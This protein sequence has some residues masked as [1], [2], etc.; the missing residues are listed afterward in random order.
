MGN[1]NI[2]IRV[3]II[4]T[5]LVKQGSITVFQELIRHLAKK[6]F[7]QVDLYYFDSRVD[8]TVDCPIQRITFKGELPTYNYDVVHS[9]GL[10]PDIYVFLN[11]KKFLKKTKFLTTI[12]SFIR[13]DLN[14]EYNSIVSSVASFFWYKILKVQDVVVVL[15]ESAKEYYKNLLSS[16]LVV[17]NNGRTVIQDYNTPHEDVEKLMVLVHKYKIIGTHA[18]I[19]HIKSL[20]T[21]IKALPKLPEY[22]FVVIGKGRDLDQLVSLAKKIGVSERCLFLG[23]R[24][25]ILPYFQYY[26]IYT[27]PSLSEGLPMALIEAVANKIPCLCSNIDTF[28]E[29]FNDEEV[30]KFKVQNVD[31]YVNKVMELSNS[32]IRNRLAENAFE[33]YKGLY[34]GEVMTENYIKLYESLIISKTT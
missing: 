17:V 28:Q 13:K 33:R 8:I 12:H 4:L 1:R 15:T 3:A 7:I 14:N 24:S 23:F 26:D 6:D 31:D 11:K 29:L 27:M 32:L 16:K 5:A 30:L 21:V 2:R 19:T 18:K 10:R 22:A 25:N 9:T 20:D 34:T